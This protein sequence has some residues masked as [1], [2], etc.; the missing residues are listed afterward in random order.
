LRKLAKSSNELNATLSDFD[1]TPGFSALN[2]N[3]FDSLSFDRAVSN[4][5][6]LFSS[7]YTLYTGANSPLSPFARIC[8]RYLP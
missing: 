3:Y 5:T 4:A 7:R 1:I 6:F 8:A 2:R